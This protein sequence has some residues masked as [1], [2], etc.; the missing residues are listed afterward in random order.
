MKA[1]SGET[2][3]QYVGFEGRSCLGK[4]KEPVGRREKSNLTR[5]PARSRRALTA[6]G[7]DEDVILKATENI[8]GLCLRE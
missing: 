2:C 8:G 4:R 3:A 7:S 6:V 1:E 5:W